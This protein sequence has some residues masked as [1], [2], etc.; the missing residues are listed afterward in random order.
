MASSIQLISQAAAYRIGA[1][2]LTAHVLFNPC[3][4]SARQADVATNAICF[5]Y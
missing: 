4:Y 5:I 2:K 3:Q 1:G